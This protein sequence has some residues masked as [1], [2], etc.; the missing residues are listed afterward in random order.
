MKVG[1]G[2]KRWV[3]IAQVLGAMLVLLGALLACKHSSG[4]SG[5]SGATAKM[6]EAIT[7]PDDSEWVVIEAKDAGKVL[8][9][10]SEFNDETKKTEGRFIQVHYKVTNKDKKEQMLIA[11]HPKIIDSQNRE[12][13]AIEGETYYVPAKAKTIMVATL[14]PSMP[15]EF[16][17]VI[18]VP[19]DAKTLKFQIHAFSLL[20]DKK[21]VD[22][23]L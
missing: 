6:G 16:W 8:K 13:S 22:L 14:Q 5:S 2:R 17:T 7:F 3:E 10:N 15:Q 9:S 1:F 23:G 12:F 21:Q 11:D 4:S 19:A 18:E 20:G